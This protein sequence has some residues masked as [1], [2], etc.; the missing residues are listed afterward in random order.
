MKIGDINIGELNPVPELE[1][2]DEKEVFAFYGLASF[3][4]QC[5][6]KALVN[7]AM[8]YRLVDNSALNQEEWIE[9]YDG[10]NSETFGRLLRQVKKQVALPEELLTHLNSSLKKR[11]W[12]AHDF[13]YDYA[14]HMSDIDGRV[15]MIKEL[16]SLINLFQIADR[17]VEKLSQKVWEHF[18]INEEWLQNEMESQLREYQSA[19]NA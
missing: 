15:E 2:G 16:Q 10:L 19:K 12:L 3:N 6:E 11:N 7:F 17:A 14:V 18:G 13:F 1:F 8:G 4:A 9:I 5:T